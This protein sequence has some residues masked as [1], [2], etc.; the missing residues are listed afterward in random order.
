MRDPYEVLGVSRNASPEEIKK[1]YRALA[2]K[3]HPDLHPGDQNAEAKMNEIN[4]AYDMINNPSKYRQEQARQ[5]QQQAYYQYQDPFSYYTS[6]AGRSSYTGSRGPYTGNRSAFTGA[7]GHTTYTYTYSSQNG[8]QRTETTGTGYTGTNYSGS[9]SSTDSRNAND[10]NGYSYYRG[11]FD[12]YWIFRN[13]FDYRQPRRRTFGLFRFILIFM[14]LQM[15]MRACFAPNY[16]N[17][18]SYPY[19]QYPGGYQYEQQVENNNL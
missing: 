6:G 3:Y 2:K 8:W 13:A 7:G 10:A 19:G 16:V 12:P 15:C 1:A 18:G 5:A 4:V 14:L 11:D 9:G 17:Y